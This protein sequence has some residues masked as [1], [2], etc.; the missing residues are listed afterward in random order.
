MSGDGEGCGAGAE[1]VELARGRPAE[2]GERL[3][4]GIEEW[5]RRRG[6]DP[7]TAISVLV[8]LT[9][10]DRRARTLRQVVE[11]VGIDPIARRVAGWYEARCVIDPAA[12]A[13]TIDLH[14][15]F[16]E[17]LHPQGLPC[18]SVRCF[19]L[20]LRRLGVGIW[21]EPWSRR[22]GFA[23]LALKSVDGVSE[24]VAAAGV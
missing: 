18:D 15:D 17:W 21:R 9:V 13:L 22:H 10:D 5:A 4:S 23:G 6:L 2:L 19:A 3:A 14:R 8:V 24:A 1:R 7:S 11:A 12:R 16:V 20:R